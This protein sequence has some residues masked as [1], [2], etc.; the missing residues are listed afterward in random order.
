MGNQNA[1]DAAEAEAGI[2]GTAIPAD[3]IKY[4]TYDYLPPMLII[5]ICQL[6]R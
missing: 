6:G 2:Q 1:A 3:S 4:L 5:K